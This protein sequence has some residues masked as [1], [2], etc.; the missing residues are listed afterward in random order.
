MEVTPEMSVLETIVDEHPR[1]LDAVIWHNEC[2]TWRLIAFVTAGGAFCIWLADTTTAFV[3]ATGL[4]TA[5][6]LLAAQRLHFY[7]WAA[8]NGG[9]A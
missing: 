9:D 3:A 4:V 2:I 8:T 7:R 5:A 6:V 1:H